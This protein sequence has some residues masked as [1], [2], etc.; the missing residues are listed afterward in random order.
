MAKVETGISPPSLKQWP[1]VRQSPI[2]KYLMTFSSERGKVELFW[3]LFPEGQ[4]VLLN[5]SI[6]A[7]IR[8][9]SLWLRK[10]MPLRLL[11][12]LSGNLPGVI[13]SG[14]FYSHILQPNLK[15]VER[16]K[17]NAWRIHVHC[18]LQMECREAWPWTVTN[19]FTSP[20]ILQESA[21]KRALRQANLHL[22]LLNMSFLLLLSFTTDLSPKSEFEEPLSSLSAATFSSN[23]F[24][25]VRF[26]SLIFVLL[27]LFFY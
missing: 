26:S 15:A 27:N 6:T 2:L 20:A 1:R 19:T 4:W 5:T 12:D 9:V 3:T 22:N 24:V 8:G 17:I 11:G 18:S 23:C 13:W 10:R 16:I 7:D 21:P 14:H 25:H